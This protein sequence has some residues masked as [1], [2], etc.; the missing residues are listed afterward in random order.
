MTHVAHHWQVE[1]ADVARE[2]GRDHL[3]ARCKCGATRE[4][5]LRAAEADTWAFPSHATHVVLRDRALL[6]DER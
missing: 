4:Y 3:E 5:P 6:A 2:A 1:A